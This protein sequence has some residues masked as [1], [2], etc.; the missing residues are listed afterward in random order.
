MTHINPIVPIHD[1]ALCGRIDPCFEL[2]IQPNTT[3]LEGYNCD[4]QKP[5][6]KTK[7]MPAE[8][9]IYRADYV[10]QHFIHYSTVTKTSTLKS[11][12]FD[13]LFGRGRLF[14]DPLSRFGDEVNEALMLHSKA[15]ARQDTAGWER[16]CHFNHTGRSFDQ[17][18]L[19]IPW[20]EGQDATHHESHHN[21][22]GW[23]YDCYV[24]RRIDDF[25]GPQLRA[26]LKEKGMLGAQ[27]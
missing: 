17:C 23:L 25:W 5:G 14:P 6:H 1:Q 9:Q 21:P 16:N 26:K 13:R 19:G 27:E 3:F 22:D 11:D 2:S 12:E 8:K 18:R 7:V 24:N 4:R 15:I 10:T 20:P